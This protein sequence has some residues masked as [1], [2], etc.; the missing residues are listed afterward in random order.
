[1]GRSVRGSRPSR[2][3][4]PTTCSR[5]CGWPRETSRVDLGALRDGAAGMDA[6]RGGRVNIRAASAVELDT[7]RE[8]WE[9]FNAVLAEPDWLAHR[10]EEVRENVEGNVR[11]GR[12]L[13]AEEAGAV[14]GFAQLALDSPR[15]GWIH[16][17]YVL[18]NA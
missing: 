10:W 15:L 16:D 4:R 2:T 5:A 9:E 17:L 11:D 3:S 1:P 13:L 18:P 12:F 7:V 8:L 14:L 6:R